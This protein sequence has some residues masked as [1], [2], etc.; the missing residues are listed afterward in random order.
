MGAGYSEPQFGKPRLT[1]ESTVRRLAAMG[2]RRLGEE[3]RDTV[4]QL[5]RWVHMN[6]V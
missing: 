3:N 6:G 4:Q 2:V 1:V 5:D